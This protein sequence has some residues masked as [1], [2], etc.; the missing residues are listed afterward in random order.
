MNGDG[1][2][3]MR[4]RVG[5]RV[6]RERS[7]PRR[8]TKAAPAT[9]PAELARGYQTVALV[10]QGGG[11][12]GSYQC[13]VYESLHEAGLRPGWFAGTSIG[14]INAAILAG[15]APERRIE[16][17]R[18]FWETIC[19]PAG[20]A[21]PAAAV[22]RSAL[23]WLPAGHAIAAWANALGALGALTWGQQG[24]FRARPQPPFLFDDGSAR[25]TS[26]YDTAPLR[27][28]LERFVDFD[29]I[30]AGDGVRLSI[31][32]TNVANGNF[33]YFDSARDRIRPEHV[34]ASGALPPAFPAVEI[35]GEH[36]WDGGL[37]SNTPL[38]HVLASTPRRDSLVFQV[39]LWS[40]R[41]GLPDTLMDV[42]ERQKDIQFSSRTRYGTDTVARLQKLRHAIGELLEQVPK[43]RLRPGLLETLEPWICD[44][45]FNIV[46]LIYQAKP[47]EEQFKDYAFGLGTMREHWAAGVA[48]MEQTL[49]HPEFFAKPP[50]EV[51][52]V[53]HDVHRL[54]AARREGTA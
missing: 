25:A 20:G 13:G 46:H 36:Y 15:N 12:L 43:S 28:T 23:A 4:R 24:F 29:R 40:A 38:D 31:G 50:P 47:Y 10:L 49:A 54:V 27:Q 41:G 17:L 16:R 1:D 51:G 14:A 37:V 34:M 7:A 35:D 32:A 39:D 30:N 44:R 18:A 6:S 19:E 26:F 22:V 9:T 42:L 21:G 8:K 3:A 48:D 11:A 2:A 45:V 5:A 53:T 33:R 52:A